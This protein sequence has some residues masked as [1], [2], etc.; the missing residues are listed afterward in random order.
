MS[1]SDRCPSRHGKFR[2]T[3]M[4]LVSSNDPT[5]AKETIQDAMAAYGKTSDAPA[6]IAILTKLKGIGP[7]TASL[8]LAV[9]DPRRVIFFA[10]EAF[11]WLCCNGKKDPIKYN[12]KEYAMLNERSQALC[13]RLGVQ[14]VDVEKVAFVM[15]RQSESSSAPD[16]KNVKA[17]TG[18]SKDKNDVPKVEAG[19]PVK[20][21][22]SG[23]AKRKASSEESEVKGPLRRSKRRGV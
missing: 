21:T 16:T 7:A 10:D 14:A 8:L 2:P 22:K 18:K 17:G 4:K 19:G 1:A 20:K 6:A 11:Y 15:M 9:H 12:A 13:K 3:L 5:S 23:P